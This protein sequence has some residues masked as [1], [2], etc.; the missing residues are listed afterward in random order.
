[1]WRVTC[2]WG[3]RPLTFFSFAKLCCI[4]TSPSWV[5]TLV[6]LQ[7]NF[8]RIFF[9]YRE[10]ASY[11]D[12]G[13]CFDPW[14]GFWLTA[15]L[16]G[17]LWRCI[18]LSRLRTSQVLLQVQSDLM[19]SKLINLASCYLVYKLKLD[20]KVFL[21]IWW[22]THSELLFNSQLF[23]CRRITRSV[24]NVVPRF[25]INNWGTANEW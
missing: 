2:R 22:V 6:F 18:G 4:T 10:V 19:N 1:M 12:L 25:K 11:A 17:C 21:R 14:L 9:H 23:W 13:P 20:F 15:L 3:D 24:P 16:F 7:L 8:S 5:S